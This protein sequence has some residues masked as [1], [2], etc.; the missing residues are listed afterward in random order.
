MTPEPLS[1]P[2]PAGRALR[3]ILGLRLRETRNELGRLVASHETG[4]AS[5]TPRRG[6]VRARGSAV[7]VLLALL[8][9][10]FAFAA[11]AAITKALGNHV[12]AIGATPRAF[13]SLARNTREYAAGIAFFLDGALLVAL[14]LGLGIREPQRL[15]VR[16]EGLL[17]L[18]VSLTLAFVA[19][20]V[21]RAAFNPFVWLTSFPL[22][23]VALGSWGHG[24][25][26]PLLAALL[27]VLHGVTVASLEF[28]IA[29]LARSRL[30]PAGLGNLRAL[31]LAVGM[32][33]PV[34][35]QP[36]LLDLLQASDGL[37][38]GHL[39]QALLR[40][41]S[42]VA[43]LTPAG[44]GLLLAQGTRPERFGIETWPPLAGLFAT[45][46]V[47]IALLARASARGLD[48]V[49][50][51]AGARGAAAR[52]SPILRL[53][54]G[55]LAEELLAVS[56][57][58][59]MLTM[60][61]LFPL[62]AILI[63]TWVLPAELRTPASL[64]GGSVLLGAMIASGAATVLPRMGPSVWLLYTVARP[65]ERVVLERAAVWGVAGTGATLAALLFL[66][67]RSLA[68]PEDLVGPVAA[69]VLGIPA[70]AIASAAVGILGADPLAAEPHRRLRSEEN[71]QVLVFMIGVWAAALVPDGRGRLLLLVLLGTIAAGLWQ[72]ARAHLPFVLDPGAIGVRPIDA[73]DGLK[74]VLCFFG[75]QILLGMAFS[76]VSLGP[77][78][79]PTPWVVTLSFFL[80]GF[81]TVGLTIDPLVKQGLP[82][83][84]ILPLRA[85]TGTLLRLFGGAALGV[86][87]LVLAAGY[88]ALLQQRL[89]HAI[90]ESWAPPLLREVFENRWAR[91]LIPVVLAPAIEEIVFRALLYRGIRAS[92]GPRAA[93]VLSAALFAL[94]HPEPSFGAIFA[95]G[96][97]C[98]WAYETTGLISAAMLTHAVYN[99]GV[100]LAR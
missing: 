59:A 88:F 42:P 45:W 96:A 40:V 54:R 100:L 48:A 9:L 60:N 87:C 25:W 58:K 82:L 80:A 63:N 43:L 7:A 52:P 67:Q 31:C 99:A 14:C 64:A 69:A 4:T 89:G 49:V 18:P 21:E 29:I 19:E 57:D 93:V 1:D 46:V 90:P 5:A 84:A 38:T 39:S 76:Q 37:G 22:L 56:R 91:I 78:S 66:L 32:L 70:L 28:A 65:V 62:A 20:I 44:A 71:V 17:A 33:L 74:G 13:A 94:V 34:M 2:I 11:S 86:V 36:F 95:L 12:V 27:T 23:T 35:F 6:R 98:A 3:L 16:I 79:L 10:A 26:S 68:R 41:L 15:G 50:S 77:R 8:L 85:P 72:R 24:Y 75:L 97:V 73:A 92:L 81:F 51:V 61:V 53:L 47:A 30:G 83:K 55:T